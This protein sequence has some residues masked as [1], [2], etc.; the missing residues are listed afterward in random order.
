[1]IDTANKLVVAGVDGSEADQ[2]T[3][4]S[5]SAGAIRRHGELLIVHAQD[6]LEGARVSESPITSLPFEREDF[7][8]GLVVSSIREVVDADERQIVFNEVN[9][10]GHDLRAVPAAPLRTDPVRTCSAS[11]T[12]PP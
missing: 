4:T 9:H 12:T 7:A 3:L 2:Q 6:V 11:A 10:P 1:M 8:E 5:A